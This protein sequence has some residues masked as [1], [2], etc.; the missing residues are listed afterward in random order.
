ALPCS[1]PGSAPGTPP[2]ESAHPQITVMIPSTVN[3]M[4]GA[5][6][7]PMPP[8]VG[9][10]APAG[11]YGNATS[12]RYTVGMKYNKGGSNPQGQVQLMLERPDGTYYIKSNSVTSLAFVKSAVY[13]YPKD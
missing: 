6:S 4:Q 12:A 7:I 2:Y 13:P 9:A 8:A 5:V 11:T 10:G 3:S 1:Q